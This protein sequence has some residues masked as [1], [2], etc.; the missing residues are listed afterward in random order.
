MIVTGSPK[1]AEKFGIQLREYV[2]ELGPYFNVYLSNVKQASTHIMF[3]DKN[4]KLY[5]G[6]ILLS[7]SGSG[8]TGQDA[9]Y[10][11]MDDP[12]T[13]NDSELTPSALQNKIN[14]VNRVVEQRIEPHT[15]YCVLHTRWHALYDDTP[16]LTV[17]KGWTTHGELEVG[18]ILLSTNNRYTRVVK[19]HPKCKVDNCFVFSNG[20]KIISNNQ[21]KW[22]FHD[23]KN[24]ITRIFTTEEVMERET[25]V[26]GSYLSNF[27]I[28][29]SN[30]F[31]S[32]IDKY[33]VDS[34][35]GNC[36]TVDAPDGMYLVGENLTPTHNSDDIIGYYQRTEPEL[37][38]FVTFP[39]IDDD[40]NV[41]WK[42][43]YSKEE[44]L[45]KKERVGERVFQ[46]VYQQKPIDMTSDF[47]NI[48][49]LKFGLPENYVSQ[50]CVRA[51]DIASSDATTN[52]DFTAGVRMHRYDD[53]CVID[54][55]V[56][57]RFGNNVNQI[58]KTTAMS[59]TPNVKIYIETG[60]GNAKL[61]YE[62]WKN[63]LKGYIVEN[64]KVNGTGSKAD[65]ATPF[66][67]ALEDGRVYM[68]IDDPTLRQ[69]IFDEMKAFPFSA[70]DDI[71]D[72]IA[73]SYNA[74]F[75]GDKMERKVNACFGIIKGL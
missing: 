42:E 6:N 8:I 21:H 28:P 17:N 64:A 55:L 31:I 39:A 54:D 4:G 25:L 9:D 19:V 73:H 56:H 1:L 59:D 23:Y 74:L 75:L 52:N 58:I 40:G 62:E 48:D 16:I 51:W 12:Y 57:G 60:V 53:Y 18:D 26:P 27:K 43:R 71:V 68:N 14:W 2:R 20:D 30:K 50:Q 7:S 66:K 41:L 5:K 45:K 29:S 49:N 37:Y 34:V 33:K 72:S 63:Q 13:G 3:C 46:S 47:F 32:L 65:R 22:Q 10:L 44:L 67:N 11:I 69:T 35:Q 15:K 38:E 70:H 24:N 36:I 61:L